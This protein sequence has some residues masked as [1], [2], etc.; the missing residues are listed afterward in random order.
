MYI[1]ACKPTSFQSFEKHA[2]MQVIS[3][4]THKLLFCTLRS[5]RQMMEV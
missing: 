5:L 3:T 4:L 2:Y 1:P